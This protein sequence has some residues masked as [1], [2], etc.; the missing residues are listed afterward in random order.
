MSVA[1]SVAA[2]HAVNAYIVFHAIE[3]VDICRFLLSIVSSRTCGEAEAALS[4]EPGALNDVCIYFIDR[5]Q[6]RDLKHLGQLSTD[7]R[8]R[9]NDKV[10][11]GCLFEHFA[12]SLCKAEGNFFDR[13]LQKVLQIRITRQHECQFEI[14]CS[15][16][17]RQSQSIVL[18]NYLAELVQ[19]QMQLLTRWCISNLDDILQLQEA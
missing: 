5:H 11:T 6:H 16:K 19:C 9:T 15:K 17:I 14:A 8:K 2:G 4:F 1:Y 3:G 12:D 13:N 7:A 18:S 10:A